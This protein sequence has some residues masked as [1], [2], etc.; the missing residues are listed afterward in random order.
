MRP[1][2]VGNHPFPPAP[3]H[4]VQHGRGV[5]LGG[6]NRAN[7]HEAEIRRNALINA[8]SVWNEIFDAVQLNHYGRAIELSRKIGVQNL[9][10]SSG[11]LPHY[12]WQRDRH[13]KQLAS[14]VEVG[15]S[16][17]RERRVGFN[18]KE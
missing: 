5:T 16:R 11:Y 4:R 8:N 10:I 3:P 7:T 13:I 9:D 18:I 6:N 14:G 2:A 17:P 15:D 12:V 1:Y